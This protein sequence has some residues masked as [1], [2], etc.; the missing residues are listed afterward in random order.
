MSEG[1]KCCGKKRDSRF[2]PDCGQELRTEPLA[3]LRR[4][5]EQHVIDYRKR[6]EINKTL[7]TQ[8]DRSEE[9]KATRS[10]KASQCNA[11]ADKWQRFLNAL[12]ELTGGKHG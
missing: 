12:D 1:L 6:A 7:A 3:D 4:Y 11:T 9:S 8:T 2:C 5:I 10:K